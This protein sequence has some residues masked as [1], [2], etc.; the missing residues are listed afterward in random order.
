M[1][2]LDNLY[3]F[4]MVPPYPEEPAMPNGRRAR[5]VIVSTSKARENLA[6]ILNHV[7]YGS[8]C[9]VLRRRGKAIAALIPIADFR[10]LKALK[11]GRH[12]VRQ[13]AIEGG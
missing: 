3:I 10:V 7:A 13:L 12:P 5:E 9:V 8:R 11:N 4:A 6:E 1:A 2:A